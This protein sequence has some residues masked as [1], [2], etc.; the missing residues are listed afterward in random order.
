MK[1]ITILLFLSLATVVAQAQAQMEFSVEGS[2]DTQTVNLSDLGKMWFAD[3]QL[4]Y[5]L[6]STGA[7]KTLPLTGK[8]VIK[9]KNVSSGIQSAEA[10]AEDLSSGYTV[11]DMQGRRVLSA[12][13]KAALQSLPRGLYIVKS[14]QRTV[15]ITI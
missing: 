4:Q 3:S 8:M 14:K 1:K 12:D 15:K 11:Y 13:S 2:A 5:K 10:A 7:T 9:F 6:L